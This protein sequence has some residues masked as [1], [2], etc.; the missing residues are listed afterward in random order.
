[1]ITNRI[2]SSNE[3]LVRQW[4]SKIFCL[5]VSTQNCWQNPR[6]ILKLGRWN[7]GCQRAK[8][9][10]PNLVPIITWKHFQLKIYH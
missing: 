4:W 3:W 8:D 7:K 2:K 6:P 9:Y 1:M 5:F 10:S